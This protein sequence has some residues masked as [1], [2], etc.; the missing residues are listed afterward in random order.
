MS[1]SWRSGGKASSGWVGKDVTQELLRI[2]F[3]CNY[4]DRTNLLAVANRNVFTQFSHFEQDDF[5]A[6]HLQQSTS[7]TNFNLLTQTV[8]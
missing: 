3:C 6:K 4:S 1:G 5:K 8:G 2:S 7:T